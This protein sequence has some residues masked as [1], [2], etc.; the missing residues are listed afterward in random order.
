M[1]NEKL[2]ELEKISKPLTLENPK[3]KKFNGNLTGKNTIQLPEVHQTN[4]TETDRRRDSDGFQTEGLKVT[5]FG[6]KY[7]SLTKSGI[8]LVNIQD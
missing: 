3:G 8:Y 4:R 1:L 7:K 2:E 6:Y 5:G